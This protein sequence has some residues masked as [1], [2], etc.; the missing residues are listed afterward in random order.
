MSVLQQAKLFI[1]EHVHLAKDA[2]H[3]YVALAVFVGAC[4]LFGW[5]ARDWKPWL[6]VLLT[7]IIG[8]AWDIRDSLSSNDPIYP[9]A[10]WKD[11]WNTML[12]PTVLM[13]TARFSSIFGSPSELSG[14]EAEVAAG[15]TGGEDDVG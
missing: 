9:W 4:L 1:V 11:I 15:P 7:A 2:L 8:E 12:L 10:N 3:I 14:D 5:K 13:L 6:L